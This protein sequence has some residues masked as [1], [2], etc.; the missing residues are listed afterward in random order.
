M[1]SI[2]CKNKVFILYILVL[3][4]SNLKCKKNVHSLE[5][6]FCSVVL[7]FDIWMD[8]K[9]HTPHLQGKNRPMYFSLA[10]SLSWSSVISQDNIS[11]RSIWF[12]FFLLTWVAMLISD[13]HLYMTKNANSWQQLL[14][15]KLQCH[16]PIIFCSSTEN[17][18]LYFSF[19]FLMTRLHHRASLG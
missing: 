11:L 12:W 17:G 19:F 9:H 2:L 1:S 3:F 5:R 14:S 13:V 4:S 6:V 15:F 8:K 10:L 7:D 16:C 18:G